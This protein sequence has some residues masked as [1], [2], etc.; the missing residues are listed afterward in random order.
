MIVYLSSS[1]KGRSSFLLG[2]DPVHHHNQDDDD[3][4]D[5]GDNLDL[6]NCDDGDPRSKG[7]MV[8]LMRLKNRKKNM[9]LE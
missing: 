2:V 4:D 7:P 6:D 5:G 3:G 8:V 9:T 1:G